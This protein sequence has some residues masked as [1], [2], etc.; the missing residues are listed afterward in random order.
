MKSMNLKPAYRSATLILDPKEVAKDINVNADG[1]TLKLLCL[2]IPVE[3]MLIMNDDDDT[4]ATNPYL[5]HVGELLK[6]LCTD[7]TPIRWVLEQE[8]EYSWF[9]ASAHL[10]EV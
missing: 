5:H 3:D 10:V 4:D 6:A 8:S 9:V 1:N 2:D 7:K